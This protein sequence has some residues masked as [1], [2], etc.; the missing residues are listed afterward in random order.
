MTAIYLDDNRPTPEGWKAAHT[1]EEA[2]LHLMAGPVDQMSFDYDLD[3]P[4]C[5]KCQF[6]CGLREGGCRAK[7]DCHKAGD[8]NGLAL[9][10]WMK[11]HHRWPKQRPTVHSHNLKGALAMKAFIAQHY[12]G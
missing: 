1:A 11:A 8:E 4:E 7:C 2:K 3:N 10:H 6:A 5:S 12:P 9:L